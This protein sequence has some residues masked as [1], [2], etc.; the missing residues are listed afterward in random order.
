MNTNKIGEIVSIYD[1]NGLS[2]QEVI[3]KLLI[4]YYNNHFE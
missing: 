3:E 1:D 2:L 4:R